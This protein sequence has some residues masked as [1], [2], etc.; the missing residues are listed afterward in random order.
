MATAT[1]TS[2]IKRSNAASNFVALIPSLLLRQK[3]GNVFAV[4]FYTTVSKF[5]KIKRKLL[6]CVP[7]LDKTW[8]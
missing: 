6:L 4:E 1:K 3:L 8:I 5:R 7:V 2:V